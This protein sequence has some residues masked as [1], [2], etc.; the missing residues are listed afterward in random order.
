MVFIKSEASKVI[1]TVHPTIAPKK[2]FEPSLIASASISKS[3]V[4]PGVEG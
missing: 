1:Y 2:K 4:H 3:L